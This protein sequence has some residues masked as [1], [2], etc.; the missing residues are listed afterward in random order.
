MSGDVIETSW[1]VLAATG[2]LDALTGGAIERACHEALGL[3]PKV[4]LDLRNVNYMSSAG[5]RI[6]LS[7]LKLASSRNGAF[8]LIAPQENVR[9]VLE[10]SG[11][12]KIFLIVD[13][14]SSLL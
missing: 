12:T 8:A 9:E 11:F 4:A 2:R 13:D 10:M 14:A 1:K 3:A 6:L 7:S 5:L